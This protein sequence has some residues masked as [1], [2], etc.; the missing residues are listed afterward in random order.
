[1]KS[2]LSLP[3]AQTLLPS[4]V[5]GVMVMAVAAGPL[6]F[7]PDYSLPG[8]EAYASP[9]LRHW[10]GTD[11]NGRDLLLRILDGGRVSLA[12]GLCGAIISLLIGTSWGLVAG[13]AR[14]GVDNLMMR[15]VDILYSVPRL[16]LI[17]VLINAF[18][19]RLQGA[20]AASG[21]RWLVGSSRLVIL[22]LSLGVIEWLTMARIVRGQTLVLRER[23]FVAAARVL[24]AGRKAIL[25]RHILPNLA[26]VLIV[27][28]TLAVPSVI[29][30]EAFLS[31]LGLGVQAPQSSW[32]SLLSEG[33]SAINPLRSAW[34]LILFP[35]LAMLATLLA[36]HGLGNAMRRSLRAK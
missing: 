24:G 16:I 33:A 1:M 23:P 20:A 4:L 15:A 12:V 18:N 10:C 36:L 7:P 17:L 28:L 2:T 35:S 6:A 9:T 3:D 14:P 34:W 22:I 25:C 31:F 32:G 21:C 5:L 27:Y 11:L 30:D 29:V 8:P 26:G 13:T 19:T